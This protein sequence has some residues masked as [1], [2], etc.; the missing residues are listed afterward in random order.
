[1]DRCIIFKLSVLVFVYLVLVCDESLARR[2]N[3]CPPCGQT[4]CRP[5]LPDVEC[6]QIHR[7]CSCCTECARNAGEYC[8]AFTTRYVNLCVVIILIAIVFHSLLNHL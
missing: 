1:M 5:I 3:K 6:E 7:R 2:R 4:K 8:S